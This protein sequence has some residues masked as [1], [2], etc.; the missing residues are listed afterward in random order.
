MTPVQGRHQLQ[1]EVSNTL[2]PVLMPLL[3]RLRNQ[4]DLDANPAVIEAHLGADSLLAARIAAL[5]ARLATAP[6]TAAPT[7][8][9][10]NDPSI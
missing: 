7:A 2:S 3:A 5:E 1:V 4:F 10:D 6:T 9:A 8:A